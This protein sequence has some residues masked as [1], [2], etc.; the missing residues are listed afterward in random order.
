[1]TTF[2]FLTNIIPNETSEL[3]QTSGQEAHPDEHHLRWNLDQIRYKLFILSG[4]GGV[5]K[6]S[7]AVTLALA[8]ARRGFDVGLLD[9]DLHGPDV[10]RMLGLGKPLS[11]IHGEHSLP[12]DLKH[13]KIISVEAMMQ[14]RDAAIIWRGAVKHKIIRQFLSQIE[15][16]ALDFLIIDA[17]PGTG[18]EHLAIAESIPE[19]RA[20]I[21]STPQEISLA[22]V[23]KSIN[24]CQKIGLQIIGVVENMSH[25]VCADCGTSIPLFRSGVGDQAIRSLNLNLLGSLPFDPQ[26]VAAADDG[27]LK[28]LDPADSPFFQELDTVLNNIFTAVGQTEPQKSLAAG[29]PGVT[30]FAV[31]VQDGRLAEQ[32]SQNQHFALI[33]VRRN[34]IVEQREA[35]PPDFKPGIL[36]AWLKREGVTHIIAAGLKTSVQDFFNRQGLTVILASSG[37]S[38]ETLVKQHLDNLSA[39]ND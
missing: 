29:E 33:T 22:D 37:L 10:Y 30:R 7:V 19:A 23:R 32:F 13:L 5:G 15:W 6:S 17:P 25:V 18:D 11:L 9:V 24:F 36:P 14:N 1:M 34:Q 21:V 35:I 27:R 20:V 26:I 4:K 39:K 2:S 28:D 38:P 31:P 16:E 8:L 3:P 12:E